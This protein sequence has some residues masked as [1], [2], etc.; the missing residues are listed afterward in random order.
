M[1]HSTKHK[2]KFGNFAFLLY[3][4]HM[5]Y[6]K[7]SHPYSQFYT[8]HQD[9][10]WWIQGQAPF[11]HLFAILRGKFCQNTLSCS[12]KR[13]KLDC[14]RWPFSIHRGALTW[15]ILKNRKKSLKIC[16]YALYLF[17]LTLQARPARP[18]MN[19]DIL[20]ITD[21]TFFKYGFR[22]QIL[23]T[24]TLITNSLHSQRTS[25]SRSRGKWRWDVL[26]LLSLT[27]HNAANL[28]ISWRLQTVQSVAKHDAGT[29]REHGRNYRR[30]D[31]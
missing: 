31:D 1:L 9:H 19:L 24:F 27:H 22:F 12:S 18:K 13:L 23:S 4:L 5:S 28:S 17:Y 7:S 26:C 8:S 6:I 10:H 3:L 29:V 20:E 11:I 16:V 14:Q 25:S 21:F 15:N 30:P 2:N